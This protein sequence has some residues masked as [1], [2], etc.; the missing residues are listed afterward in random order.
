[1]CEAN[2][3]ILFCSYHCFVDYTSGA[4]VSGMDLLRILTERGWDCRALSGSLLDT[5][6]RPV[7]SVLERQKFAVKQLAARL[8]GLKVGKIPV[9][10]FDGAMDPNERTAEGSHEFLALL[11]QR[12]EEF[13]PSAVITYGGF[14]LGRKIISRVKRRGIATV[15]WLRNC[16][17]SQ[18]NLFDGATAIIVPSRFAADFYRNRLGIACTAIPPPMDFERLLRTDIGERH[19]TFVNPLSTKGVYF[20]VRIAAVLAH[21]RSDIRLLVV[22]SR[23]SE[24]SLKRAGLALDRMSNLRVMPNTVDPR[25]FYRLTHVLLF[26]SLWSETF[27]RVAVEAMANGIPVLA[28]RRGGVAEA[29]GDG[30]F[31]FD[32]PE[33]FT[34]ESKVIPTAAEV[35]PWIRIIIRL[36]DDAAFYEEARQRCLAAAEAFRPERL[37]PLYEEA[38]YRAMD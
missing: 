1:M 25:D 20:F 16:S 8:L 38:L 18:R 37:A 33:K 7:A 5:R 13:K 4:A 23:G 2:R 24:N 22:E 10:I 31:L 6:E 35:E 36:W 9:E 30:G 15:F 27:G 26:P 21:R 28:S 29:V 3:R 19:V 17:Y 14:W 12:L 32:I 34:A 11:E